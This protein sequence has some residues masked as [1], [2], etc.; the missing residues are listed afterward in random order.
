MKGEYL[1]ENHHRHSTHMFSKLHKFHPHHNNQL[2]TAPHH[3][4]LQLTPQCEEADSCPSKLTDQIINDG[5]TIEV[6]RR[7]RGR[8]PGS[9]NKPKPTPVIVSRDSDPSMTPY[10][11]ELPAGSDI[12]HSITRFCRKRNTGLSILTA[13]GPVANVTLRQPSTT[14]G[15]TVTFHG[16]FDIL[17]VSATI[18]P[19][20]IAQPFSNGFA[21]SLA[22]P[23]G[24]IVGGNVVGSLLAAGT[25]YVIAASFNNPSFHRLPLEDDARNSG[26]DVRSPSAV[27]GGGDSVHPPESCGMSIYNSHTPSSDV[28]LW[29]P[30]A[31]EA[32]PPPPY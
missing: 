9:K 24:Q 20:P 5:A 13:S 21:I 4:L 1:D 19:S 32:P 15:A 18:L 7:P 8:P 2:I 10:V 16:R 22:G 17:S 3:H 27:S 25:V 26:T 23:Q 29:A 12:V 6:V 11:L 28:L 14:P 30:A 31:R